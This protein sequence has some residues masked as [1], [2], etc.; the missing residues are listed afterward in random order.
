MNFAKFYL[1]KA[2]VATAIIA[3]F[4]NIVAAQIE[5][6]TD[7]LVS[8]WSFDSSSIV[9][10]TVKDLWGENHGVMEGDPEITTGK[11][12][13]AL[14]FDGEASYVEV[15]HHESLN[16]KDAI[17][18][19][20]WFLLKGNSTENE[21]PRVVSKGQSTTANGAYSIWVRDTRAPTDIGFRSVTLTPNDIR[22]EAVPSYDDN[23][24]HHVVVTYDGSTG[25][26][27]VDGTNLAD[28]PVSGDI[29]QTD[30]PLQ[31][32]NGNDERHFNGAIDEVRI[33]SRAITEA[34]ILQNYSA[35]SN[36]LAVTAELKLAT[37]WGNLKTR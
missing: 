11:I 36:S 18:I 10:G 34:E 20:C 16:L 33:Y 24:W 35:K 15:D 27:F 31:I 4:T 23:G 1:S 8:F 7:G 19:E 37:F 3:L 28:I 25:K 22:S 9:G 13:Q 5:I 6:V 21:Y 32:G 30:E 17:T 29:A 12:N 2:L 26:L 14:S